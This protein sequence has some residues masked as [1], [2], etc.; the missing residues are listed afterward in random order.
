MEA[1]SSQNWQD[2]LLSVTGTRN[3]DASAIIEY[4]KPLTDHL[5]QSR[6]KEGYPIGWSNNEFEKFYNPS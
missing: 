5:K 3:L 2:L 6:E 4:F 1:G